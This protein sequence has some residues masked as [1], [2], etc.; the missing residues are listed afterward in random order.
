MYV[1]EILGKLMLANMDNQT[2]FA[3]RECDPLYH[4]AKQFKT[5]QLDFGR[6]TGKTTAIK[7]WASAGDIVFAHN[8]RWKQE[9]IK[10]L[11]ANNRDITVLTFDD[12]QRNFSTLSKKNNFRV[13]FDETGLFGPEQVDFVYVMLASRAKQFILLG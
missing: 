13:W 4:Y 6:A 12:A 7:E 1:S 11:D 2:K 9:L 10:F 8:T 3:I 5:V